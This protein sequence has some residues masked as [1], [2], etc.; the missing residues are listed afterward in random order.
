L[1]PRQERCQQLDQ[2]MLQQQQQQC[3]QAMLQ[4]WLQGVQCVGSESASYLRF[5]M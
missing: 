4:Q 2:S 1:P 5:S 3:E